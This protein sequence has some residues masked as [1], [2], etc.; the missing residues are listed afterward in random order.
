METIGKIRRWH[1]IEK[2]SI[3]EIAKRLGASRNAVAKYLS[4]EVTRLRYKPREKVY[5]VTGPRA[6]RLVTLLDEDARK[7]VKE[8]RNGQRLYDTL[9]E[10]GFARRIRRC[11]GRSSAG[12][13]ITAAMV[14]ASSFRS[15]L[16]RGMRSSWTGVTRPSRSPEP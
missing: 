11:S 13:K 7:P 8:R 10:E 15:P 4:G 9:V 6:V 12:R 16:L 3:S 5:P 2:L 1:R 14:G